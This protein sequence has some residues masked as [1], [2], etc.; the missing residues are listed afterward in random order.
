MWLE[1]PRFFEETRKVIKEWWGKEPYWF[2]IIKDKKIIGCISLTELDNN[3][4]EL[5]YWMG[6]PY[7][8]NGF[9]KQSIKYMLNYAYSTL[10]VEN[11]WCG[12][13]ENNTRSEKIQKDCGFRLHHIVDNV[14]I[15]CFHENRREFISLH[16]KTK[17]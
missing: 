17:L 13:F 2:V 14:K 8:N 4:L 1:T 6:K 16:E 5:G 10:N 11:V 3:N 7:R 12:W 15:S 9:M